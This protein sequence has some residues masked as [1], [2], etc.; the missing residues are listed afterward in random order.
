MHPLVQS[1]YKNDDCLFLLKDLSKTM[2]E[3][4]VKEFEDRIAKGIS[5]S[6]VI[7]KEDFVSPEI[8]KIFLDMLESRAEELADYVAI[9]SD[10]ALR[11]RGNNIILVSLA[12]AGSPIGVLMR[13]Y[14]QF[15]YS[16]SVPHYS[17][18]IIRGKGIDENALK[19]IIKNHPQG[20]ILFIDGWTGKGSITFEL[21]KSIKEFNE[22]YNQNIDDSLAVLADPAKKSEIYGTRK[23][24]CIPNACLDSTVSGLVSRTIHNLDYIKEG[25]FHGA[26]FFDSLVSQDYS[27]YF[28][29]KVS[30]K[31]KKNHTNIVFEKPELSYVYDVFNELVSKK[32][33]DK[34]FDPTRV[35]LSIGEVSRSVIR[36]MPSRIFVKNMEDPNVQFVT[37]MANIKSIPIFED[38]FGEYSC[39]S[40]L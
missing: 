25:D 17:I 33:L 19:Y 28:I 1:T 5:Y 3:I 15:K 7:A 10:E 24:I 14:L 38:C 36:R 22:K 2:E 35:K 31:F 32:I 18:S 21:K 20:N 26:K 16:I 6:E 37:H 39:V 34:N 11:L 29:E 27:N 13:K 12:R 4:S 8:N 9:I 23:D 30:S 40:I